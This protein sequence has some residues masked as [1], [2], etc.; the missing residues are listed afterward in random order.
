MIG[1]VIATHG[2]LANE[3]LDTAKF[4][5]GDVSSVAAVTLDPSASI[6]TFQ[7]SIKDAIREVDKGSGVII[8][9]DMFGGTPSNIAL[10]FLEKGK[11]D[12]ITGVNL[13][14]LVKFMQSVNDERPLEEVAADIVEYARK[15]INHANAILS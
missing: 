3:L 14:M 12:V 8:L 7:K 15:S 13:P 10:S 11:V 4:I 2:N 9:T 6:E 1:V 5:I